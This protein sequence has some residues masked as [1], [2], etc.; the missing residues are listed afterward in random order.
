MNC[1][2]G[3]QAAVSKFGVSYLLQ[4]VLLHTAQKARESTKDKECNHLW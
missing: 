2:G 1:F 4:V 3:G